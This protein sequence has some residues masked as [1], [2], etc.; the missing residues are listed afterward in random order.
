M[1]EDRINM[2]TT[3]V[4]SNTASSPGAAINQA[5]KIGKSLPLTEEDKDTQTTASKPEAHPEVVKEAVERVNEYVQTIQR[6]LEFSVDEDLDR[7]I[8]KVVDRVS[9]E[10]IRQI[11]DETFLELARKLDE[12]GEFQLLDQLV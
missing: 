2:P 1:N 8:V 5:E 6:N 9:G 10:V 11:P 12:N 7:T 4:V 3:R